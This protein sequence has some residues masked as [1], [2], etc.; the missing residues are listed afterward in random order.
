MF[1]CVCK[2]ITDRQ[3]KHAVAEGASS[4]NAVRAELGVSSQCGQ[5]A[6]L[7]QEIISESLADKG[8]FDNFYQVA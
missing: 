5:C 6:C 2:G 4:L 7:A 8:V 1:V 3:I